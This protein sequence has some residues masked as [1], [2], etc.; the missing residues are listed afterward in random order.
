MNL[1]SLKN[2]ITSRAGRQVLTLQ[3]HSPSIL[4]GAGIVGVVATAVLASKATLQVEHVLYDHEKD[5]SRLEEVSERLGSDETTKTKALIYTKTTMSLVKL[6]GPAFLVG[7]ASIACLTSSHHIMSKRN[8]GL[9][10]AYAA[11]EKGFNQY[12]DRVRQDLGEDADRK[13]RYGVMEERIVEKTD[14][15]EKVRV[16]KH[17][18]TD[19]ELSGYAKL[20][21]EFNPNWSKQGD[22]NML[23]LRCQQN[24]LNDKLIAR[25]HLFLNEVYDALGM[26]HTPEG[27]VT[28]WV[29]GSASGDS[30]VDFGIFD[31]EMKPQHLEFFQ[32]REGA[33]WLDFN[34]D[35]VI[36]D[37]I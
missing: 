33:I 17:V 22:Y 29:Y 36:Y 2:V 20:F 32:G 27:A 16:I 10:A 4:F 15:G 12:R 14:K 35:G 34:V 18:D 8:A 13:Y 30:C 9:M 37:K 31:G 6:Y 21:D 23:F 5:L 28:G 24:Y 7:T 25:G 11:V 3:K 1:A 19:A 26:D